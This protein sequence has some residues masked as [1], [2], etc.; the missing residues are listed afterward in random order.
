MKLKG[1]DTRVAGYRFQ[2][3]VRRYKPLDNPKRAIYK[4]GKRKVCDVCGKKYLHALRWGYGDKGKKWC[5][6]DNPSKVDPTKLTAGERK[7]V[8]DKLKPNEVAV[9]GSDGIIRIC[10]RS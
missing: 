10:E 6:H 7:R 3:K 8:A 1:L 9:K 4:G 5:L 2:E